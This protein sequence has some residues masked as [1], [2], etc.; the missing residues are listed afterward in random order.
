M[1]SYSKFLWGGKG[2]ITLLTPSIFRLLCTTS[3]SFRPS[4]AAL[5]AKLNSTPE[6]PQQYCGCYWKERAFT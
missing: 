5:V 3:M 2:M 6:T 1:F 4:C